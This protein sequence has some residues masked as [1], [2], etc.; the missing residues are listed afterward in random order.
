VPRLPEAAAPRLEPWRKAYGEA[1]LAA[2]PAEATVLVG[3]SIGAVT[4]LRFLEQ[5]D[6]E[7]H[8]V[9]AGAVLVSASAY[10]VGYK[11]L[12]SFFEGEFDWARIRRSAREFRVLQAIDDPV[13]Q[14]DPTDHVRLFVQGLGATAVLTATGGHFGAAPDDHVEVPEAVRL[15]TEL[16]PA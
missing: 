8:G 3:H 12:A 10:E 13:N 11:A 6:P 4:V 2:G 7:T 9:F 5:H 16:L 1:A 15:V 14:P